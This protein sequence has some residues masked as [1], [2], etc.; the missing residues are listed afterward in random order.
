MGY[1]G[2]VIATLETRSRAPSG[3][4]HFITLATFLNTL[5]VLWR[6]GAT[7]DSRSKCLQTR[8]INHQVKYW[9]LNANTS[10]VAAISPE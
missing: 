2:M 1:G 9:R 4:N 3:Y 5:I 8:R 7:S 10:I 6:V